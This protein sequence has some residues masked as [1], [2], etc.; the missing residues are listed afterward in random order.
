MLPSFTTNA[1]LRFDAIR[2]NVSVADPHSLLEI[3]AGEGA[4]AA[5]I[6]PRVD[7]IG[8]EQ[9]DRSRAIAQRRIA[10]TGHGQLVANLDGVP[11]AS[12]DMVCA[13]E[14]LEH[15]Q[16]DVEAL[17]AWRLRL[18]LGGHVLVSVPA[19]ADRFGPHDELA[20]HY[21]RYD[22]DRLLAVLEKAGFVCLRLT[23][24]G[25]GLGQALE[26]GRNQVARRREIAPRL[27]QRT[28]ASGR[29][30]QPHSPVSVL[31]C[32]ALAAPFRALQ[33]PLALRDFGTGYVALARSSP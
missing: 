21:R 26:W 9:D 14:V 12:F 25:V 32:A 6:A 24:H 10:R 33:T 5:W 28:A 8:V 15:I 13:F 4:F 31:A 17:E 30:L 23:S 22:R 16:D 1:W 19:H 7:Y 2:R 3:G 18:K 11:D 29:L 20:G 27:E